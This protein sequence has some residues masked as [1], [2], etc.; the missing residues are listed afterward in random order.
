MSIFRLL[1]GW[2]A[3]HRDQDYLFRLA[4]PNFYFRIATA[5][6]ILR[7]NGVDFG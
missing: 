1:P 5:Y 6:D 7:H 2:E 4:L 3:H